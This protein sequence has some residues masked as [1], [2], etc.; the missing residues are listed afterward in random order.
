MKIQSLDYGKLTPYL[1]GAIQELYTIIQQ[2]Q[3]VINNLFI[4]FLYKTV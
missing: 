4:T 1:T 2:Q 3:T